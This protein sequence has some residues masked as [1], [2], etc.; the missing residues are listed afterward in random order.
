MNKRNL[1]YS[2]IAVMICVVAGTFSGFAQGRYVSVYSRNQVDGFVR[3]LE[4]SSNAFY[5]DFRNE[6]NN[7]GL[8][9]S[10]RR[11]YL[12]YAEQ[13]ENAVDRLRS[14]FN[15]NNSWWQSRNEVRT[16][17]S[18]SQNL[19]STMNNA[20]FR[21]RLE[22]QWNR[23]RNDVDKLADT[24]DLP[25]LNG[26]GWNGGGW[27]GGGGNPGGGGTRPPAWAQ[28]TFY[29]VAPNGAQIAL[30]ID[31]NGNATAVID[32]STSYGSYNRGT[33]MMGYNSARLVR[34]GNGF[35]TVSNSDGETINY[36]RT[37]W[38]GGNGGPRGGNP[39]SW[40]IGSFVGR[41]PIDGS[42]IYMNVERNGN[43]TVT[44][45]GSQSYGSMNEELLTMGSSS[46]RVYRD[47]NGFRTVSTGDGQTINYRRN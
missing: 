37:G 30:T 47:G 31:R 3:Q 7:S 42:L 45:G 39:P 10:T 1:I 23:L 13:F 9:N 32:G 38:D 4:E 6:V 14:R 34:S 40:A 5:N 17:I 26:G 8:N 36:S 46:A 33:L 18:N 19:N 20:T 21:R 24:Y 22:R 11:Q 28:G 41:S 2:M 44:M 12:G 29:G 25:G 27:N 35:Q 43:V 16:M 15:S